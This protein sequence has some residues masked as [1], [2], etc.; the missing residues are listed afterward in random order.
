M[1]SLDVMEQCIP[2][3]LVQ[4]RRNIPWLTKPIFQLIKK[5]T[6]ILRRLIIVDVALTTQNLRT[7]LS[8]NSDLLNK[9]SSPISSLK[10]QENSGKLTVKL[11]PRENT[12][13]SLMSGSTTGSS[14]PIF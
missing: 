6:T 4:S 12:I 13:P 2:Q 8:L 3:S 1:A 11:G 14:G 10:T 5:E 7:K 9:G